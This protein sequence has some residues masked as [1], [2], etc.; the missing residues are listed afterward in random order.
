MK[1]QRGRWRF[2]PRWPWR[3][4]EHLT[5]TACPTPRDGS[6]RRYRFW[7]GNGLVGVIAYPTVRDSMCF[8]YQREMQLFRCRRPPLAERE[9]NAARVP[10]VRPHRSR[11]FS[12]ERRRRRRDA[13]ETTT[14]PPLGMNFN[15]NAFQS[16]HGI[17]FQPRDRT[18]YYVGLYGH[19]ARSR[20]LTTGDQG[21]VPIDVRLPEN[22]GLLAEFGATPG[23]LFDSFA[24]DL[25]TES[26][27]GATIA[28]R[29]V[30]GP[31]RDGSSKTN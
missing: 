15:N 5:A 20:S 28:A 13:G 27:Y 24:D 12:A 2:H 7:R 19:A 6:L 10:P 23:K 25:P 26:F 3:L 21:A 4:A 18:R 29:R 11:P 16:Q 9:E 1:A 17:A 14:P 31:Y 8:A 22:A 30:R